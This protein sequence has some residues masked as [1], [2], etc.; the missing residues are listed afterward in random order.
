MI[1]IAMILASKL[2]FYSIIKLDNYFD[3]T[4]KQNKI[5]NIFLFSL[6]VICII[7]L[8]I[9]L[10][11]LIK[12]SNTEL[13]TPK[14]LEN[15]AKENGF[16]LIENSKALILSNKSDSKAVIM[17]DDLYYFSIISD[18]NQTDTIVIDK[19]N[20]NNSFELSFKS[21]NIYVD[22]ISNKFGKNHFYNGLNISSICYLV[23]E[24]TIYK[25]WAILEKDTKTNNF[26]IYKYILEY[27]KNNTINEFKEEDY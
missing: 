3:I 6:M 7:T 15:Y 25:V 23:N 22:E 27:L 10:L 13:E 16:I 8:S 5:N 18:S 9:F 17:N 14:S 11:N 2:A 19:H 24:N 26:Y 12:I 21:S 20:S 4:K 1:I